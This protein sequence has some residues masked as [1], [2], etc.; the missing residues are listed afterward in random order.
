MTL[1]GAILQFPDVVLD[2]A[3]RDGHALMEEIVRTGY[4]SDAPGYGHLPMRLFRWRELR[5]LLEPYG[6]IVAA[7]AAGFLA[8]F[9]PP[10]PELRDAVARIELDLAAEPG[11]LDAGPHVLAVLRR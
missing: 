8:A 10:E 11:A 5:D 7:S 6:T 3:R 1:A 2:L 9:E 4:L